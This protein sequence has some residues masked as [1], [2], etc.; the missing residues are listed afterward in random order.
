MADREKVKKGLEH[1][2]SLDYPCGDCPYY[3][4]EDIQELECERNL[5]HD[6]LTLLK[7]QEA[8]EPLSDPYVYWR[9]G[10]CGREIGFKH[11]FC[12]WCGR[13]VKWE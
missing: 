6:A 8:V 7:E 13:S 5:R 4:Y 1:C 9:C 10:S 12:E 11:N 2:L 3:S